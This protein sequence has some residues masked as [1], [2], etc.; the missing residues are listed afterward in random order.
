VYHTLFEFF[1]DESNSRVIGNVADIVQT[2]GLVIPAL[3]A[4]A[5]YVSRS[6][7]RASDEVLE[8]FSEWNSPERSVVRNEARQILRTYEARGTVF[9]ELAQDETRWPKIIQFLNDLE[10]LSVFVLSEGTNSFRQQMAKRYLASTVISSWEAAQALIFRLR[11]RYGT[12]TLFTE[13]ERLAAA[14]R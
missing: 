8:F 10:F 7:K 12:P 2:V 3:V 4:A 1:S 9:E 6:R 14:W 11:E 13:F 5:T